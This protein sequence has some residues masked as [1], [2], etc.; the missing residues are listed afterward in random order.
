M[1]EFTKLIY[2]QRKS[3][4]RF[5]ANAGIGKVIFQLATEK[6]FISMLRVLEEG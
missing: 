4:M 5:G 2:R 3:T 6:N 1:I